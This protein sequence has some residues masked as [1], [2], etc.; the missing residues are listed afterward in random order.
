MMK[1][2]HCMSR[3]EI[4]RRERRWELR[5]IE[6]RQERWKIPSCEHG[7]FLSLIS[8]ERTKAASLV[9]V[10]LLPSEAPVG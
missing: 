1:A 8:E 9:G 5:Q 6:E 10:Q 3:V 7:H 2:E 4:E